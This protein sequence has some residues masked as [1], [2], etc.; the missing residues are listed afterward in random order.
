MFQD[1]L[2]IL[3]GCQEHI[4]DP[5]MHLEIPGA[6]LLSQKRLKYHALSRCILFG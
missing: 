6:H 1:L 4:Q 5:Q 2:K 3:S